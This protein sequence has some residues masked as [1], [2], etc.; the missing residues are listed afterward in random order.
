[1]DANVVKANQELVIMEEEMHQNIGNNEL[2]IREKSAQE[3]LIRVKKS[4][5]SLL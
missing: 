4:Q 3:S 1:M 5:Y 2:I